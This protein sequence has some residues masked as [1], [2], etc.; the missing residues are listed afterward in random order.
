[1]Q[2]GTIRGDKNR[3]LAIAGWLHRA[4]S[5]ISILEVPSKAKEHHMAVTHFIAQGK[6]FLT[7]IASITPQQ[8]YRITQLQNKIQSL[9]DQMTDIEEMTLSFKKE[10]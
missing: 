2:Q 1:M 4:G 7:E 8:H 6:T 3:T 9:I 10:I 5:Q